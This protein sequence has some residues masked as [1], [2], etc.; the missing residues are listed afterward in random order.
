MA[1]GPAANPVLNEKPLD[2]S[3]NLKT[4]LNLFKTKKNLRSDQNGFLQLHYGK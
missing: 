2:M 4:T 1:L 3:L